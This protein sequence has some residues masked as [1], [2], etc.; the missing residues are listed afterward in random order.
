MRGTLTPVQAIG[1]VDTSRSVRGTSFNEYRNFPRDE[2]V[3]PTTLADCGI[4]GAVSPCA[5]D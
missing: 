5:H 3:V 2:R 1:G 4:G